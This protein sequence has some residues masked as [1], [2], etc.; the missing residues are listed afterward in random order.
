MTEDYKKEH[1]A[2]GVVNVAPGEQAPKQVT[3]ED[4][5]NQLTQLK[6][7]MGVSAENKENQK[8]KK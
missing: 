2:Q 3:Y 5:M 1:Q 6:K 7:Q 4:F 8:N